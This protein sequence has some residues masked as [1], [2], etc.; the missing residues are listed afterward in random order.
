MN[1]QAIVLP[2]YGIGDFLTN[3]TF[4]NALLK[5]FPKDKFII[6]TKSRTKAKN[7][8]S[9]EKNVKIFYIKDRYN[10]F[11]SVI[12]FFLLRDYFLKENTLE[13]LEFIG[14]TFLYADIHYNSQGY[15]IIADCIKNKL[16]FVCYKFKSFFYVKFIMIFY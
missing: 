1:V 13:Q 12:D 9:N 11:S 3:L 4:I 2:Y 5:E 6:I 16:S 10:F 15:K 8:M 7:L 14:Q